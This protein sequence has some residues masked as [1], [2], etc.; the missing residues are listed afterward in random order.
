M[1]KSRIVLIALAICCI[2]MLAAGTAAYF[3]E[4]DTAVNIIT[5]GLLDMTLVEKTT[6]GAAPNTPVDKLPDFESGKGGA[7]G[8]MPGET[9]SKIPYV[10]NTGTA[11][12]YTRIQLTKKIVDEAGRELDAGVITL[13]IS[14]DWVLGED[15]WYYYKHVV[16]PGQNTTPLFTGV[17]FDTDMGNAYQNATTTIEVNAQAVQSRNNGDSVWTAAGWPAN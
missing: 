15:G 5:T 11:D 7:F 14:S 8:V 10:S 9:V 1:T 4:Q 17:T 2:A 3:V 16:T 13:N 12:F 6:D